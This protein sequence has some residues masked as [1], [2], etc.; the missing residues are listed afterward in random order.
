MAFPYVIIPNTK[1][2]DR[3]F[4]ASVKLGPKVP[5]SNLLGDVAADSGVSLGDVT[6]VL[7]SLF[8][9]MLAY[10]REGRP[11][12]VI[13]GLFKAQPSISGSFATSE[14]AASEIK[15]GVGISITIGPDADEALHE[16]LTVEKV[17]EHGTVQPEPES[18]VLSPG[19]QANVYSLTAALKVNGSN[20]RGSGTNQTWPTVRLVDTVGNNSPISLT[21]FACSQTEMLIGPAPAGTTGTWRLEIQAGWDSS[22]FTLYA[23]PLTL[24][25]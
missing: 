12:G 21:V 7:I 19:G 24:H 11:I 18:V 15:A 20:F 4:R 2:P 5:E 16:N 22:I 1:N 17:G 10:L 14:P 6:K 23:E 8:K 25:T 3:P 9:V 13:L